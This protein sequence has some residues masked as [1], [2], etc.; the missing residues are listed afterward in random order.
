MLAQPPLDLIIASSNPLLLDGL[1]SLSALGNFRIVAEGRE[2]REVYQL[3]LQHQP[4][5]LVLE[6]DLVMQADTLLFQCR[7]CCPD[8]KVALLEGPVDRIYSPGPTAQPDALVRRTSSMATLV[9]V[10]MSLCGTAE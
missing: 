2:P 9:G 6:E 3:V 8:L 10:I 4:E 7:Q 5:V 1:R